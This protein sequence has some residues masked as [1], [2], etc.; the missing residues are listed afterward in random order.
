MRGDPFPIRHRSPVTNDEA[1]RDLRM[2]RLRQ[3]I[4]GGFRSGKG[5]ENFAT[6]RSAITSN[7]KQGRKIIEALISPSDRPFAAD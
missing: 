1:E 3:K 5:A 7:G 4:F 6:P 2:M